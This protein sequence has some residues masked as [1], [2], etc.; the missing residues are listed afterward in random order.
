MIITILWQRILDVWS[1]LYEGITVFACLLVIAAAVVLGF[2]TWRSEVSIR[3]AGYT[4]QLIGMILAIR[5]VL[6]IRAHFGQ[7]LLRK[8]FLNWLKRFSKRKGDF[9]PGTSNLG[10][11]TH[12]PRIEKWSPDDPNLPTE[13]RI[14][15]IVENLNRIK[16]ELHE[17]F[18]SIDGLKQSHEEHKKNVAEQ[19][20]KMKNEIHSNLEFLL[21]SDI[22]TSLVGLVWLIVGSTMSTM[23]PELYQWLKLA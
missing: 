23:A 15:R 5:S 1:G 16:S 20:N 2:F 8:I 18:N 21:T 10:F 17:H 4:L 7:T 12:I 14:E 9:V 13:K 6:S 22:I 11:K 19:T 3:S